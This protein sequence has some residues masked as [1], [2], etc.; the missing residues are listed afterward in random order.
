[1][2]RYSPHRFISNYCTSLYKIRCYNDA[3]SFLELLALCVEVG[4]SLANQMA[5]MLGCHAPKMLGYPWHDRGTQ[6]A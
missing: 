5:E 1:M 6:L 2:R 4:Y 3:A